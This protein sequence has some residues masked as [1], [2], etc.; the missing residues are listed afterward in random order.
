VERTPVTPTAPASST[1]VVGEPDARELESR[2][3]RVALRHAEVPVVRV[4]DLFDDR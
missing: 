4:R 3:A 1:G 2:A